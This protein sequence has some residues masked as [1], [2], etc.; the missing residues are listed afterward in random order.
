MR[1]V[2]AVIVVVMEEGA[3]SEAEEE[4]EDLE[5]VASEDEGAGEACIRRKL[6]EQHL[7][8]ALGFGH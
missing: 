4:E 1:E 2:G 5:V 3:A 8:M 6:V 7:A